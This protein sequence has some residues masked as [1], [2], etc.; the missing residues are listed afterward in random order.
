MDRVKVG[1]IGAGLWGVNHIEAYR[2]MPTAE[3]FAVA[4]PA[5]GRAEAIARQFNIRIGPK[6]PKTYVR[7]IKSTP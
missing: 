4:D 6:L 5:P 7:W 2:G 3:V 1:I